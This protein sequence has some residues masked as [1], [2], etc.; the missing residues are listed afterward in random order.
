MMKILILPLAL[1]QQKN[2]I[3]KMNTYIED[4]MKDVTI[5]ISNDKVI[6]IEIR[7]DFEQFELLESIISYIKVHTPILN[8]KLL[9][10]DYQNLNNDFK[11]YFELIL[12]E[13][14]DKTET[15]LS[16]KELQDTLNNLNDLLYHHSK[17]KLIY[18]DNLEK[19][20]ISIDFFNS[21]SS[22]IILRSMLLEKAIEELEKFIATNSKYRILSNQSGLDKFSNPE[23]AMAF[24]ILY[25]CGENIKFNITEKNAE[26]ILKKYSNGHK[27]VLVFLNTKNENSNIE[28]MKIVPES[29]KTS[30]TK[31][32][33]NLLR[34]QKLINKAGRSNVKAKSK[35]EEIIK[36]YIE[37]YK[38]LYDGNE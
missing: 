28:K 2:Q 20:K 24:N 1:L 32:K 3:N 7:D 10:R 23:I 11:I 17:V 38:L 16:T 12:K 27:S 8:I 31:K 15:N 13:L 35:I 18:P 36:T 29:N 33:Y 25:A 19:G 22:Q 4:L 6:E 37:K 26:E 5:I 21:L 34:V 14:K 30:A 9:I